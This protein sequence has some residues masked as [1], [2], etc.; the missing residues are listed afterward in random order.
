MAYG[1]Y[2]GRNII[3]VS[4]YD[5]P[6]RKYLERCKI[7]GQDVSSFCVYLD[8]GEYHEAINCHEQE[9][10][11]ERQHR[12]QQQLLQQ[13]LQMAHYGYGTAAT[14]ITTSGTYTVLN[15][16]M[17]RLSIEKLRQN[18]FENYYGIDPA[19]ECDPNPVWQSLAEEESKEII[20]QA[21][22]KRTKRA[23]NIK[24]LYWAR[25]IK[26]KDLKI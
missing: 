9:L 18:A 5:H 12:E 13:Q 3:K 8:V 11:A 7:Y 26:D 16:H 24:K 23:N 4:I 22:L 10:R 17:L 20:E 14:S 19:S 21:K 15:E 25:R 2:Y 6:A 1:S